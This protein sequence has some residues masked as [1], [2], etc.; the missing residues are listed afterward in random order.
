MCA[1]RLF[2]A[3]ASLLA[4]PGLLMW[5]ELLFHRF[6]MDMQVFPLY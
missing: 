6:D 4:K 5:V 1:R 2:E 3:F